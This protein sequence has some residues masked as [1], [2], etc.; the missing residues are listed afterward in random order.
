MKGVMAMAPTLTLDGMVDTPK[1]AAPTP[2]GLY[3]P[4]PYT[5]TTPSSPT[6]VRQHSS[7]A[8]SP[9]SNTLASTSAVPRTTAPSTAAYAPCLPKF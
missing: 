6:P 4:M 2:S 7:P 9:R 8:G 5:P 1:I 3:S